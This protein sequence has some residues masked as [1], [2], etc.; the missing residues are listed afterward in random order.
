MLCALIMLIGMRG[1]ILCDAANV[2]GAREVLTAVAKP[3][4]PDA[5]AGRLDRTAQP[6]IYI[7]IQRERERTIDMCIYI[8]IY[9]YITHMHVNNMIYDTITQYNIL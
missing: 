3:G 6:Y 8:Y 5:Q 7:Y 1:Y 4:L 2:T 9:M